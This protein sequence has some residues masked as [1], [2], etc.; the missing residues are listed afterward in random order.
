MCHPS[1]ASWQYPERSKVSILP[2]RNPATT[3]NSSNGA[4]VHLNGVT[5]ADIL[6]HNTI[7][8]WNKFTSDSVCLTNIKKNN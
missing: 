8:K 5:S 4:Y 3:K 7:N 2:R 1:D 6:G